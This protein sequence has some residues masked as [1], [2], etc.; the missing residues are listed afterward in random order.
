MSKMGGGMDDIGGTVPFVQTA[1]IG[2]GEILSATKTLEE[3]NGYKFSIN[4]PSGRTLESAPVG[5]DYPKT[6][7]IMQWLEAVKGEIVGDAE[8]AA[9]KAARNREMES[10]SLALDPA[11]AVTEVAAAPPPASPLEYAK[12]QLALA[13]AALILYKE[14]EAS[15]R[16]WTT[17]LEGLEPKRIKKAPK[18]GANYNNPG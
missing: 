14:S 6:Q 18:K 1:D 10:S 15:V 9:S 2:D 8:E 5:A 4:L 11:Y 17:I 12:Q 16:M 13:K 3:G 7:A